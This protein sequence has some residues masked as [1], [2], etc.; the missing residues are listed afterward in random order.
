MKLTVQH[1]SVVLGKSNDSELAMMLESIP[2]GPKITKVSDNFVI[3][4]SFCF[5]LNEQEHLI[6]R[7]VALLKEALSQLNHEITNNP[8][9]LITPSYGV[10][11]EEELLEWG[12]RIAQSCPQ[13]F[14]H[15]DSRLFPYGRASFL[16]ALSYAKELLQNSSHQTVWLVGVESLA[17]LN[18]LK[19]IKQEGRLLDEEG[20]GMIPS[21][22]AIILGVRSASNGLNLL[23]TGS[24]AHLTSQ[25]DSAGQ[26]PNEEDLAVNQ[27]FRQA[28]NNASTKINQLYLP[29]HSNPDIS[30]AWLNQYRELAS[31][32]DKDTQFYFSSVFTGELGSV[33]GLYRFLLIHDSYMK[34]RIT[35][36]SLQCEISDQL[37]RSMA[38][39]SWC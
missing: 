5:E 34:S 11:G 23:W 31:V 12:E 22:G 16:M 25:H 35:G 8:V 20:A 30:S 2:I 9:L 1:K 33:G 21:E 27:L 10:A 28:V 38:L 36:T 4:A 3:P 24:D 15:A 26:S 19:S 6:A 7:H 39:F 13:F 14:G 37:Y 17:N 18:L 32:V 29:D